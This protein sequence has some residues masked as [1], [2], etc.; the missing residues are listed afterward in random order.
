[1]GMKSKYSPF[2]WSGIIFIICFALLLLGIAREKE[3]IVTENITVPTISGST[4]GVPGS[5][6]QPL[7]INAYPP[8]NSTS[9]N[10]WGVRCQQMPTLNHFSSKTV[11]W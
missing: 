9:M 10:L 1:M 6:G 11:P 2:L 3:I 8:F 4:D 7:R 5:A